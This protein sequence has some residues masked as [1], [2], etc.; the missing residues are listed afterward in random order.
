L[1]RDAAKLSDKA[2]RKSIENA[3]FSERPGVGRA[4]DL[5][6]TYAPPAKRSLGASDERAELRLHEALRSRKNDGYFLMNEVFLF[7]RQ[8]IKFFSALNE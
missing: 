2:A 4:W 3:G 6:E 7:I 5:L 8:R 1:P